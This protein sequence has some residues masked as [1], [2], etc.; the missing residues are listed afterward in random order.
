MIVSEL[1]HLNSTG[2]PPKIKSHRGDV[3]VFARQKVR[4]LH[5]YVLAGSNKER[6]MYDQLGP[7]DGWLL[8]SNVGGN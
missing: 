1:Q 7:V 8:Q 4:W 3:E 5:E 6:V 2:M